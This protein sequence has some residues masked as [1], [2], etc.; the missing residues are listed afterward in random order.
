MTEDRRQ[1][2]DNK[3]Y[4]PLRLETIK[5]LKAGDNVLLSGIIYTARD[6]AHKR[7][8]ETIKKGKKLPFHLEGEVIFYCGPSPTP[9]GKIIGSCGPTT[10]SRMDEFT[11]ILLKHGLK[12]MIGKG[13][14]SEEVIEAIKKYKAIYFIAV[15][16]AG[17]YLSTKIIQAEIIAYPELGPEAIYKL[18]VENFSLIV[19]IDCKGRNIYQWY[20]F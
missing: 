18:K 10:S 20:T 8:V 9:P 11:P 2:T 3:I 5:K 16:G 1:K 15:G 4:T 7:I 19:G 12:G 13:V 14:R 6:Q 17:A